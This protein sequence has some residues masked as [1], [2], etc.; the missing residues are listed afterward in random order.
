MTV[1]SLQA[2]H[3]SIP[4][5][6]LTSPSPPPPQLTG[7]AK[8]M[9]WPNLRVRPGDFFSPLLMIGFTVWLKL[10]LDTTRDR[11]SLPT[12][13]LLSWPPSGPP[14]RPPRAPRWALTVARP[15]SSPSGQEVAPLPRSP[16][17]SAAALCSLRASSCSFS[18]SRTSSWKMCQQVDTSTN[19]MKM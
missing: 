19:P 4:S 18:L 17:L 7:T 13:Y 12:P 14:S 9:G 15:L 10:L 6:R 2:A 8:M 1:C 11:T 16:S 5:R 3:Q